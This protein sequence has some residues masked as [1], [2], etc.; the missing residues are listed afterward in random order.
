MQFPECRKLWPVNEEAK[1]PALRVTTDN[2][3]P[4]NEIRD[5]VEDVPLG[6]GAHQGLSTD[7][8]NAN[9]SARPVCIAIKYLFYNTL[10]IS[11]LKFPQE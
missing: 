2:G 6:E 1:A 9:Q 3:F 10:L 11:P 4:E 5:K 8:R 7:F